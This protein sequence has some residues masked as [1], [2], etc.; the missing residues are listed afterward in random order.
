MTFLLKDC[1][2]VVSVIWM[3][4]WFVDRLSRFIDAVIESPGVILMVL[5]VTAKLGSSSYQAV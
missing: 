5:K 1:S 4:H 3:F 2:V